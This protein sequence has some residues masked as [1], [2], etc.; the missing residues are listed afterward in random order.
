ME[1]SHEHVAKMAAIYGQLFEEEVRAENVWSLSVAD[2][3]ESMPLSL[4]REE[5]EKKENLL[6]QMNALVGPAQLH[7]GRPAGARGYMQQDREQDDIEGD[8]QYSATCRSSRNS[9]DTARDGVYTPKSGRHKTEA[10]TDLALSS[11]GPEGIIST[12]STI[13]WYPP[14]P[15]LPIFNLVSPHSSR[16]SFLN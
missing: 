10:L 5:D 13:T 4:E 1:Y 2:L 14:Q 3:Q 12:F 15:G 16:F 9:I 7:P 11:S 8:A 6:H